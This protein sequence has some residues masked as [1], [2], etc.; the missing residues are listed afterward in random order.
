VV[1][2]IIDYG[3]GIPIEEIGFI[4]ERF[5][6]VDKSRSSKTGGMGIGLS[7]TKAIIERHDGTITVYSK[8]GEGTTFEI[9]LPL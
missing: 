7:I 2:Q 1:I 4:F 8:V 6:R 3:Q 9:H 5:Y